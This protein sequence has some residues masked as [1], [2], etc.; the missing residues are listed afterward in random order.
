MNSCKIRLL[1]CAHIRWYNAEAE[2]VH[3]LARGALE[4]GCEVLLWGKPGSPL[5]EKA[6]S[7]GIPILAFGDPGSL[8][9]AM[10]S[11]VHRAA[12]D[13]V[14]EGR[15][16]V[17]N[18]LR[19][20]GFPLI[21]A[22]ARSAGAR[23]VRTRADM[24]PPKLVPL[25]RLLHR[26]YA[27]LVIAANDLIREELLVRLKLP[28]ERVRTVRFGIDPAELEPGPGDPALARELGLK[29]TDRVVGLMGRLGRV[30]GQ[31][32]ALRAAEEVSARVPE[33]RF[34]VIYRDVEDSDRF[35]SELSRS[36]LR[37]RFVLVGPRPA[38]REV[39]RLCE[40]ALIPS[41]GSEANCRVALEWMALAVPVIGS[42]VGV[43][44]ELIEH[45]TTGFLVQPRYGETL[46][47]CLI[48][49]LKNPARAR[50][51]GEAGRQ[52]LL[53]HFTQDHMVEQSLSA[54]QGF[55]QK[56]H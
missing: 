27:D 34:L 18:A 42:R 6:R 37:D 52:R 51:M 48:E 10:M 43:I 35:L 44:P 25:N 30:K 9:P 47:R 39:M 22:A 7:D 23:V 54:F 38:H 32:F 12:S 45:G 17:V 26:N 55:V 5:L 2:Y 1:F 20:E 3:R 14:R 29:P 50:A 53:S 19:S 56:Q 41:V 33:A 46:A 21:A 15:F 36:K 8:N 40:V 4:R 31:E 24:R 49:L 16:Q 13:L 28:P 11:A